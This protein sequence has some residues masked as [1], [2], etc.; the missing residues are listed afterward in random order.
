MIVVQYTTS[1]Q[2]TLASN[3]HYCAISAWAG[4][5]TLRTI[6]HGTE[7]LVFLDGVFSYDLTVPLGSGNPGL[8]SFP[9][10]Y[11]TSLKVG[12]LATGL[13]SSP[14]LSSVKSSIAPNRASLQWQGSVDDANGPG[15]FRY[16][17]T[18]N[19]TNSFTASGPEFDDN[20]VVPSTGYQY[21][22]VAESYHGAKSNPITVNVST[23]LANAI[24][25]RRVGVRPT[26]AYWGSV[27]G[28]SGEQVDLLS[29]NLNY[30]LPLV[31]AKGRGNW[32]AN[33]ALAYN[34]Q[35]W[36]SDGGGTWKLG[37]D[38]GYGFGWKLLAG[39]IVPFWK[40][41]FTISH[42]LF[43][44][45]TGAEYRLANN[46]SGIW[47]SSEGIFVWFDSNADRLYFKD[48]SFWVMGCTSGGLESDAGTLYPTVMQDANGNQ[49]IIS[50]QTGLNAPLY[51]NSSARIT[52][53]E[54]VRA[55]GTPALTYTFNYGLV[56]GNDTITHLHS[57]TN[58]INTPEAYTFTYTT[59]NLNSPFSP[60]VSYG[61]TYSLTAMQSTPTG[62]LYGFQ[63]DGRAR[64]N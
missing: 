28:Q 40:D 41:Q 44:D 42:Y 18:Q 29:G 48:G 63:Y 19:G 62:T 27:L 22:I 30:N 52:T 56:N 61:Q 57:I 25:P 8:Y 1:G 46:T 17:I 21:S 43:T 60:S 11:L 14:A 38:V 4:G 2:T 64:G 13:P 20:T 24:D 3:S 33:F 39:S 50:Y 10:S 32:S 51:G 35:N 37:D 9:N 59:T 7:L 55:V 49:V 58:S 36:R 16:D 47:S 12:H 53:I 54:D 45:S 31:N 5:H 23:P 26:G 6:I 34:S 15:V